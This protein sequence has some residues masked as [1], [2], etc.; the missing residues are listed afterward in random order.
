VKVGFATFTVMA[1]DGS[2]PAVSAPVAPAPAPRPHAAAVT[3]TATA[4]PARRAPIG[5]PSWF[6]VFVYRIIL[7]AVVVVVTVMSKGLFQSLLRGK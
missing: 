6:T 4:A 3:A 1:D 2:M 5:G 7:V